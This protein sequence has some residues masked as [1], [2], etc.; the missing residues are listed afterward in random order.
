MENKAENLSKKLS[1]CVNYLNAVVFPGF[2]E[3]GNF[4]EM[5][6]ISEIK[7]G[8][9]IE[10][11]SKAFVNYNCRQLS[12]IYPF[13]LRQDSSNLDIIPF[14]NVGCQMGKKVK[15]V[16]NFYQNVNLTFFFLS[17]VKLSNRR[18]SKFMQYCQIF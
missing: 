13:A 17:Y 2:E 9:L 4:Y 11:N 8:K 6:S 3:R 5:S 10:E 7:A 18:Y 15:I 12:R 1:K 16:K 14:F